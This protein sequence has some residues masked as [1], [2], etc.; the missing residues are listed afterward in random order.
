MRELDV[1]Q[2]ED[3]TNDAACL[4]RLVPLESPGLFNVHIL[5]FNRLGLYSSINPLDYDLAS[6]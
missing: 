5:L 1:L 2:Q 3:E 4:H 6:H